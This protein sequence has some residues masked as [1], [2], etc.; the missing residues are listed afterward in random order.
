MAHTITLCAQGATRASDARF[1]A[2]RSSRASMYFISPACPAAIHSGNRS[3]SRASAAGAIPARSNP[4]AQAARFTMDLMSCAVFTADSLAEDGVDGKEL[5]H[6]KLLHFFVVVFAVKNVP[7]LRAFEDGPLLG[8]DLL[9]GRQIDPG[10]LI[11]QILKDLPR[12][13][14]DGVRILDE[15]DFVHLL[16]D[17]GDRA[18]QHVHLVAAE[19][20]ST[21]LYLR[22]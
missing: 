12:L 6:A 20:H 7:L 4:A 13:L 1:R 10:F 22:T 8:I 21:A 15:I 3:S 9:P 19:P 17:V 14:P 11:Q 16:E 18:G 2:P 5:L